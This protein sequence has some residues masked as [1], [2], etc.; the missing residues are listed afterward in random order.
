ME[1]NLPQAVQE[2]ADLAEQLHGMIYSQEEPNIEV[3]PES[4]EESD[5]TVDT[6]PAEQTDEETYK[7]RYEVLQGKYSKEVP[8]MAAELR[9]MREY[10]KEISAVKTTKP[11]ADEEENPFEEFEQQ[12]S[13]EFV[14]TLRKLMR[15]EAQKEASKLIQPVVEQARSAEEIQLQVR[16]DNF[17]SDL[18]T[19]VTGDWQPA[20]KTLYDLQ[21]G[22]PPTD[23]KAAEFFATPD[24]SGLYTYGELLSMYNDKWDVDKIAT[25]FNI[26][27]GNNATSKP[28]RTQSN[29]VTEA[30][31]APSRTSTQ[32]QPTSQDKRIWTHTAIEEFKRQD[33]IG[34]YEPDVSEAMWN[35]LLLAANENRI[36]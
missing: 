25:I 26:Y 19:K 32:T 34:K 33:R 14:E 12:Y 8:G 5:E 21:E 24:P 4:N 22:L 36:R 11:D 29:P 9:E 28:Q 1:S 20:A 35:D 13:P 15:Y 23:P 7:H 16:R 6:P 3:P 2:A 30:L 17:V 18:S 27:L 10:I 31:I